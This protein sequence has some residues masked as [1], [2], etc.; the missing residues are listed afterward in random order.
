MKK[1]SFFKFAGSIF[2]L[3]AVFVVGC[4]KE[5]ESLQPKS[6]EQ[7]AQKKP[8]KAELLELDDKISVING[9]L[10]FADAETFHKATKILFT[11]ENDIYLDWCKE[12]AFKSQSILLEEVTA[13]E[14]AI[15]N[16]DELKKFHSSLPF[17]YKIEDNAVTLSLEAP[18]VSRIVN[19]S[20]VYYVGKSLNYY[21]D[22]G[23]I[24]VRN[25]EQSNLTNSL[26]N[27]KNKVTDN[28]TIGKSKLTTGI[29]QRG[30]CG[31][32]LSSGW[33]TN[34]T[35]NRRAHLDISCYGIGIQVEGAP[36]N[37][38]HF[39]TTLHGRA[40]R[41]SW[42]FWNNYQTSNYLTYSFTFDK[43]VYPGSFPFPPNTGGYNGSATNNYHEILFNGD[44]DVWSNVPSSVWSSFLN[45]DLFGF[46][47]RN[48]NASYS[49]GGSATANLNCW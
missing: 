5:N 19:E 42:G 8:S 16:E 39:W 47:F 40:Q 35:N 38:I 15:N 9:T 33:Q 17:I 27:R 4:N 48:I 30:V 14:T 20:G 11:I 37:D 45:N 41:K 23:F 24:L 49:T 29:T 44:V 12:K 22:K 6:S 32:Y 25:G 46:S 10:H 2:M 21:D 3:C 7:N 13:K 26:L 43:P 34:S 31:T 36:Q 28:I 18:I 1:Q